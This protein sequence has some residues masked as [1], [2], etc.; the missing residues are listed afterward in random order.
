MFLFYKRKILLK[1]SIIYR[2]EKN[3]EKVTL[4]ESC[5]RDRRW[6]RDFPWNKNCSH[7][8]PWATPI[9][10]CTTN[11]SAIMKQLKVEQNNGYGSDYTWIAK[12]LLP[13]LLFLSLPLMA[14]SYWPLHHRCSHPQWSHWSGFKASGLKWTVCWYCSRDRYSLIIC[15]ID[16]ALMIIIYHLF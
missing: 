7:L 14:L 11:T 10:A 15:A 6:V 16:S 13:Q 4:K 9:V 8:K 3:W 5:E 2:D 1:L 12:Y